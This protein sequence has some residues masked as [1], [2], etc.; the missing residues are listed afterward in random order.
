MITKLIT[1]GE[2]GEKGIISLK[3]GNMSDHDIEGVKVLFDINGEEFNLPPIN[4]KAW[5]V[6]FTHIVREIPKMITYKVSYSGNVIVKNK[7]TK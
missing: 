1:I 3:I 2:V 6:N 7:F 4:V 5:D